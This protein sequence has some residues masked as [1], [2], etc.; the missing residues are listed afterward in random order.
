M[1]ATVSLEH[2]G[3]ETETEHANDEIGDNAPTKRRRGTKNII[4]PPVASTL[5]MSCR[6]ASRVLAAAVTSAGQNIDD[7][8][9]NYSSVYRKREKMRTKRSKSLKLNFHPDAAQKQLF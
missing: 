4:T 9:L 8:T 2:I 3:I 5:G 1:T 7:F 6:Q